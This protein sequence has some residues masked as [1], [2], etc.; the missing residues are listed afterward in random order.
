MAKYSIKELAKRV[1]KEIKD[2]V[3]FNDDLTKIIYDLGFKQAIDKNDEIYYVLN[4]RYQINFERKSLSCLRFSVIDQISCACF[5]GTLE[6]ED[7][8]LRDRDTMKQE[9]IKIKDLDQVLKQKLEN[10]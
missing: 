2:H 6:K 3:D 7:L 5:G 4:K 8:T 9:R 1:P 10:V